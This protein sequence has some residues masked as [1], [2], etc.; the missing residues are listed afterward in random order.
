MAVLLLQRTNSVWSDSLDAA[1]F[2][3]F[4]LF[5][6]TSSLCVYLSRLSEHLQLSDYSRE[7]KRGNKDRKR[8]RWREWASIDL[9][10]S[11]AKWWSLPVWITRL[12][13]K[14]SIK[15]PQNNIAVH[16]GP[17]N[18]IF[19]WEIPSLEAVFLFVLICFS[20][21]WLILAKVI[22]FEGEGLPKLMF[23]PRRMSGIAAQQ[24]L[25]VFAEI[26]HHF[27][28]LYVP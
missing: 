13:L 7:T 27:L 5:N 18:A 20:L 28:I 22:R 23:I 26:L 2:C 6:P 14:T 1:A 3:F 17:W 4:S 10:A 21:K 19:N 25:H 24:A 11:S 9:C 16:Q 8:G 12:M 15:T